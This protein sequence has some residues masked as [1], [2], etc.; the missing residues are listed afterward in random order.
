MRNLRYLAD[1]LEGKLGKGNLNRGRLMLLGV[2]L[3]ISLI[4]LGYTFL[5]L[6]PSINCAIAS[7]Q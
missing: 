6:V 2:L 3:V 5:I 4:V 7:L 1:I